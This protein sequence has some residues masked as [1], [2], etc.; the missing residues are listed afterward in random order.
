MMWVTLAVLSFEI[1]VGLSRAADPVREY[2]DAKTNPYLAVRKKAELAFS[3]IETKIETKK[4]AWARKVSGGK[5]EYCSDLSL[6]EFIQCQVYAKKEMAPLLYTERR[7]KNAE[8]IF[9]AAK[10]AVIGVLEQRKIQ[11]P[12]SVVNTLEKM[13][14]DIQRANLI[15]GVPGLA[16]STPITFNMYASMQDVYVGGMILEIDALPEMFTFDLLHEISHVVDPLN[17]PVSLIGLSAHPFEGL[18][19][20]LRGAASVGAKRGD[21]ECFDRLS[22]KYSTSDPN[23]SIGFKDTAINIRSN[24]DVKY[25]TPVMESGEVCQHGQLSEA[26]A[27]WLGIEAYAAW[28]KGA[29][30]LLQIVATHCWGIEDDDASGHTREKNFDSHPTLRDRLGMIFAHPWF[31]A[32]IHPDETEQRY[33]DGRI[34]SSI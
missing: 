22:E 28:K 6:E 8:A 19:G 15:F 29:V 21:A 10:L 3:E 13:I 25:F 7:K 12:S 26:F 34:Q 9:V 31:R 11:A 20:C 2:C 32:I 23:K 16:Q 30:D 5:F 18:Y 1:S 4:K 17:F 27:D 33:C 24:P 14:S